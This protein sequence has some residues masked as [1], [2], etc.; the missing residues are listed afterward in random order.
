LA[1]PEGITDHSPAD[2]AA[3]VLD[4]AHA[5]SLA[6]AD[7]HP[8]LTPL[9]LVTATLTGDAAAP[10]WALAAFGLRLRSHLALLRALLAYCARDLPVTPVPMRLLL[11][12]LANPTT[13][14]P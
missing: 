8:H 9:A 11:A 12:E 5:A 7:E 4:Y 10:G 6:Q 3:T 2:L 13:L 14:Q 1:F